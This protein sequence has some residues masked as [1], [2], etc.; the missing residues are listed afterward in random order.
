MFMVYRIAQKTRSDIELDPRHENLI[1]WEAAALKY[2]NQSVSGNFFSFP[3]GCLH[4][5]HDWM[6]TA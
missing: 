1:G 6:N 4:E 2:L 5:L 3:Q